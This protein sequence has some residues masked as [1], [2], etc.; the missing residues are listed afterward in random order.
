MYIIVRLEGV[1]PVGIA[2]VRQGL[3]FE[4]NIFEMSSPSMAP[5]VGSEAVEERL[6]GGALQVH[7]EAGI[8]AQPALVHLIGTVLAFQVTANFFDKIR[9]QRIGIMRNIQL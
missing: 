9:G 4:Q 1:I 5:F 3:A 2:V 8:D 7:I 6:V